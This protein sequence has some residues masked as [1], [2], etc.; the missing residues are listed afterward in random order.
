[1]KKLLSLAFC[2]ILAVSCS[3]SQPKMITVDTPAREPGQE[4]MLS[5]AADPI[6]VVRVGFVGVGARGSDA[7]RRFT[8]LQGVAIKAICDK[9][10]EKTERSQKRLVDA[11][12]PEATLYSGEEG[13]K[14]LCERDDIDLVYICT[15]WQMHVPVALY[16]M[17]HGKHVAI[18]VPAATSL[19][20]CW[21]L[22]NTS[23]KTRRHCMM[24]ENCCYDFFEMAALNMAQKGLFGELIH[25]EG[26]YIH[27][28]DPYWNE[29]ADNWRL[30]FN[31]SHGGDVYPTHGFGP[32]CQALNIHRG[33]K[34]NYLVSFGTKSINGLKRGKE[35]MGVD[36]FANPD[37]TVTL[38]KTE[39]GKTMEIQH[40]VFTPREY[41]RM[42]QLV[43]TD[44][45]ANKYPVSRFMI[46]GEEKNLSHT[47]IDSLMAA[48]EHPIHKGISEEARKVGGHGGM[49]FVMDYR[50][51]YCLHNGL[52]LDMDVYD[53]AEW[54]C[55]SELSAISQANEGMPVQIPDFT[56]GDWNKL[57]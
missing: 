48:Y 9:Y 18:E 19:A 43:G 49:D 23:E 42:Y 14:Q 57:S 56:R 55:I 31:Q 29:Y 13:Y 26:A 10:A 41:S 8:Y 15:N 16:A 51:I 30:D 17:E 53:L 50:L 27:N 28:L 12:L 52:P 32:C 6:P 44:G 22:V 2:A 1:M 47:Q 21:A 38:V 5:F 4:T 20:D 24:L 39:T 45:Y 35:K 25:T 34:L 37:H 54:C 33:D 46:N 40:N 36:T 3:T 11:G 7:V